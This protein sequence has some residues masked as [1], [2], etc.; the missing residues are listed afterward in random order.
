MF[1]KRFLGATLLSSIAALSMASLTMTTNVTDGQSIKGN[2]KFDIRVTSS[3]LVS[4]VEFYVGDDLKETDDST[5]YNFQLD[6]INEAEGPIKVTFAA[7]NTNGE[8][9]K[10]VYNLTIDNGIAKGVD[11]HV[12]E[13][14]N[15]TRDGKY[16][17]A[18]DS[19]RIALKI[20]GTNVKAKMAMARANYASGTFDIAQKFS[21]D[22]LTADPNNA[23]AKSLLSAISLRRAFFAGGNNPNE[24]NQNVANALKAAAENYSSISKAAADSTP[25]TTDPKSIDVH[26]NAHRYA[27][28]AALLRTNWEKNID[29]PVLTNRFVYA[30]TMGGRLEEASRAL[31][32]VKRY[33]SPDAYTFALNAIVT[34]MRGD[35]AGSEAAEKEVILEDPSGNTTKYTQLYLALNRGNFASMTGYISDLEKSNPNSVGVNFYRSATQFLSGNYNN[36]TEPAQNALLADPSNTTILVERGY[37]ILQGVFA[38][39]LTGNDLNNQVGLAMAYFEAALAANP[40][41]IEGLTAVSTAHMVKGDSAK[42]LSFARAAVGAAPEYAGA[43]FVLAGALRLSQVDALKQGNNAQATA[44]R[45]QTEEALRTAGVH[46]SRLKG[47]FAPGA[48]QAWIYLYRNGRLPFMPL[49][50]V[51]SF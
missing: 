23:D 51:D 27:A 14:T 17:E 20:D 31:S 21:E 2:F 47:R 8:S 18:I 39:S 24:R 36:A 34:Q 28:V 26:L 40:S 12:E 9:V 30:L 7:Y 6:T 15:Y 19:A 43:H 16:K 13:S 49:P 44:F 41:S 48:E 1:A 33:G 3:V 38:Q 4:N 29:N 37:Q 32:T 11:F 45:D 50:P 10:K 46:D 35:N 42:A 5:P 25:L 22:V